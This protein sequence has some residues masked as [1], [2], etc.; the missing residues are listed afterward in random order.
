MLPSAV[1][2]EAINK[3]DELQPILG[4]T[5]KKGE[6][7]VTIGDLVWPTFEVLPILL[8]MTAYTLLPDELSTAK[9]DETLH[10]LKGLQDK[11]VDEMED[12][13]LEHIAQRWAEN[14]LKKVDED[15][16]L[17]V[18]APPGGDAVL[19]RFRTSVQG[20]GCCARSSI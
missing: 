20:P 13:C 18:E 14:R 12:Q 9:A 15:D 19:A 11:H 7:H 10:K 17:Q 2:C 6:D 1:R 8:P 4:I 16:H 5:F 3:W